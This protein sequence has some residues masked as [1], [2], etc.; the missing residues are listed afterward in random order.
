MPASSISGLPELSQSA[1]AAKDV[2]AVVSLGSA[3]TKKISTENYVLGAVS[4][5]PDGSIDGQKIDFTSITLE[6]ESDN[7]VDGA[8]TAEKL[9][10]EST[11]VV[12][13]SAPGAGEFVGQALLNTTTG[14]AY[15][16]DG[17]AWVGFKAVNS[18]NG[19][20][21][22]NS[23]RNIQL[24]SSQDGDEVTLSALYGLTDEP[25]AFVAGPTGSSGTITQRQIVSTDLPV[26]TDANP[27]T[28]VPGDGLAVDGTGSLTIDNSVDE[29]SSRSVVTYDSNG[30]ITSGGPIEPADLPLAT[31]TTPGAVLPGPDLSVDGS[32]ELIIS[33]TVSPGAGTYLKVQVSDNGLVQQGFSTLSSDD[34]GDLDYS[35]ITSGQVQPGSIADGAVEKE[36]LADYA[37]CYMQEGNPGVAEYLG[38]MWYQPSTAQL[39]IYARGSAGNQWLPI[40]FGALQANN[41]R[42]MGTFNADT[43]TVVVVTDFGQSAGLTAGSTVPAPSDA[44]GGGYLVCQVGGSNMDQL[45]IAS[46]TFTPGDW[47][48]CVSESQG[49]IHIDAAATNGGGGGGGSTQYLNDLLDVTIA[50]PGGN[51]LQAGQRLAYDGT[52]GMWVNDQVIEGG[53]F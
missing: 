39:R 28:I 36:Q 35:Q 2:I 22:F 10:D 8:V 27:G 18:I 24:L 14:Y 19:V 30:L 3:E 31:D 20:G 4:K 15:V 37:T 34:I 6:I 7:I 53:D 33:N 13:P 52:S 50:D 9:G 17:T 42:W 5:L 43:N 25:R 1:L 26:A 21:A 46:D 49:W 29:Q 44:L 48:L 47:A 11:W 23:P 38:E 45:D 51:A 40:G 41:L 12:D 32:G 16:W